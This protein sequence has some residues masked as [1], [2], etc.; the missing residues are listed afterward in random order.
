MKQDPTWPDPGARRYPDCLLCSRW[1]EVM[2]A[3]HTSVCQSEANGAALGS[4][5]SVTLGAER[6][7]KTW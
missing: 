3:E 6:C 1:V 2:V 7:T 4:E 5:T